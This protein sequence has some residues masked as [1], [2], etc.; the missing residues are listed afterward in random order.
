[1]HWESPSD[2]QIVLCIL[3]CWSVL[4]LGG[5]GGR[6]EGVVIDL[7]IKND[8]NWSENDRTR[9]RHPK[10]MPATPN[11]CG[12]REESPPP[13]GNRFWQ[14]LS[15][16]RHISLPEIGEYRVPGI[17]VNKKSNFSIKNLNTSITKLLVIFAAAL[18]PYFCLGKNQRS[19][20]AKFILKITYWKNI[21]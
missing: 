12:N 7:C 4:A 9:L 2:S 15:L 21:F 13:A 20:F 6:E 14:L 16:K 11:N 18:E 1:M 19:K 10:T 17:F 3:P 5:A 8:R